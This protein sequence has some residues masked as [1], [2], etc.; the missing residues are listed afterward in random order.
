MASWNE[1]PLFEKCFIVEEYI[2][3]NHFIKQ[4]Q[5]KQTNKQ[6][7]KANFEDKQNSV[8]VILVFPPSS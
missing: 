3:P 6:T 8:S 2:P 4:R 7:K 1:Q 5:N